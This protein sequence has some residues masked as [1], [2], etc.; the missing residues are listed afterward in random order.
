[1]S[2]PVHLSEPKTG[3]LTLSLIEPKQRQHRRRD[4]AQ[5]AFFF[6][7]FSVFV[8][9]ERGSGL[10]VLWP[11]NDER[12]LVGRMSRVRGARLQVNHLLRIAVVGR[13]D[14][15]VTRLLARLVDRTDG[16]VGV[17]NGLDSRLK[18]AG[19]AD[20]RTLRPSIINMTSQHAPYPAV[21]NCT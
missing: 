17:G 11:R 6:A 18:D 13:Y 3:E 1:L 15:S 21:R 20:L 10:V 7:V 4:I 16:C 9:R 2:A 19:M 5:C 8:V 14:Q 12:D